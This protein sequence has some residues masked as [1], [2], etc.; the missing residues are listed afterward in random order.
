MTA[1]GGRVSGCLAWGMK[2]GPYL[3]KLFARQKWVPVMSSKNVRHKWTRPHVLRETS[4]HRPHTALKL[5]IEDAQR[6]GAYSLGRF[7]VTRAL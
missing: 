6:R 1:V 3:S 4:S 2:P 5:G 7:S